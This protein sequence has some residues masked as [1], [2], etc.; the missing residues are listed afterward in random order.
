M[1]KLE[2]I[3]SVMFILLIVSGGCKKEALLT[4]S[5]K[6]E[7]FLNI[8]YGSHP[9]NTIDMYLPEIRNKETPVILLVYG[10]SW[11]Q[12]DK[13]SFT[14]LAKYWCDKGYAAAT[15][16]YRLT[17]T[18]ENN[19]YMAQVQDIDKA[20]EFIADKAAGWHISQDK[21]ALQGQSSGA[22]LSLL[23]S[24]KFNKDEKVKAV[25]SMAGPTDLTA[26]HTANPQQGPNLAALIGASPQA[27]PA[28]YSAASPLSHV[29]ARSK[30]TLI[31]HGKLD[32][33]VPYQQSISLDNRLAQSGIDRK[34]IVFEDTG[35]EVLNLNNTAAFLAACENWFRLY[36]K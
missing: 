36:L 5:L 34:L 30:P 15:I 13:S 21:F 8:S 28:A 32:P 31:F 18:A 29:N 6:A 17:N 23:Y 35:H 9:R 19:F 22:H 20:I 12:G 26:M 33:I 27:N 7:S 11:S 25:I 2:N 24:Y 16:N 1:K 4:E 3:L 10:D 14:D